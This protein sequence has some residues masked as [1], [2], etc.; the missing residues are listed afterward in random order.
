MPWRRRGEYE[1]LTPEQVTALAEFDRAVN[2]ATE[3]E[4]PRLVVPAVLGSRY[5][6]GLRLRGASP[7][8]LKAL[9]DLHKEQERVLARSRQ[10]VRAY[11]KAR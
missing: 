3:A 11:L 6:G 4:L 2:R 9:R 5:G 8:Q 1:A 7:L 10:A